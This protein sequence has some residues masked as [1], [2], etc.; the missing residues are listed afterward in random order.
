MAKLVRR[1]KILPEATAPPYTTDWTVAAIE[2]AKTPAG[3]NPITERAVSAIK[4][5]IPICSV[6]CLFNIILSQTPAFKDHFV[7][8]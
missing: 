7:S 1:A 5:K 4:V 8:V 3:P 6:F 2:P